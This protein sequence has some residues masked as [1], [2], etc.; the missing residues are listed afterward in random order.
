M[1]S[2]EKHMK[3]RMPHDY[4]KSMRPGEKHMSKMMKSKQS[5]QSH[6]QMKG[7]IGRGQ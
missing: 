6:K 3:A 5:S 7:K 4:M 1:A 2:H